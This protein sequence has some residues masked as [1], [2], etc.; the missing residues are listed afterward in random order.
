MLKRLHCDLLI[1]LTVVFQSKEN[2]AGGIENNDIIFYLC[3]RISVVSKHN[4]TVSVDTNHSGHGLDLNK[5][6]CIFSFLVS[7]TPH[8]TPNLV[9]KPSKCVSRVSVLSSSHI[10]RLLLILELHSTLH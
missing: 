3:R 4:S 2:K 7:M 5:I 6:S 9:A 8:A 10:T 1:V